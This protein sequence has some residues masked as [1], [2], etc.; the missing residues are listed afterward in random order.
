[1]RKLS[2]IY[3]EEAIDVLTE[4]IDPAFTIMNDTQ[5]RTMLETGA[6]YKDITKYVVNTYRND[7]M[8]ILKVLSGEEDY[9]PSITGLI[10]DVYSLFED[11]ELMD[12]FDSQA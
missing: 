7:V 6:E 3:G 9:N 4:L 11:E 5:L 12:F 1:M 8:H 2:E 10:K